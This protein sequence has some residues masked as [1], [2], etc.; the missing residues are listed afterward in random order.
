VERDQ[1]VVDVDDLRGIWFRGDG[2]LRVTDGGALV[3]HDNRQAGQDQYQQTDHNGRHHG[4][5]VAR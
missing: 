4:K 1:L 3:E 5:F 2:L